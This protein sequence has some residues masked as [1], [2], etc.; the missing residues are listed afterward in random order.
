MIFSKKFKLIFK[1]DFFNLKKIYLLTAVDKVPD[2][3]PLS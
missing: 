2:L 1:E 3:S